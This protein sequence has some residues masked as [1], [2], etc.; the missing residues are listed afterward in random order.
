MEIIEDPVLENKRTGMAS[1][2]T[3]VLSSA[4]ACLIVTT[5]IDVLTIDLERSNTCSCIPEY[6]A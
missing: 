1:P 6:Q 4:L 3:D 2:S 5:F